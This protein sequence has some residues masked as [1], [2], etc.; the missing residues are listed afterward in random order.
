MNASTYKPKIRKSTFKKLFALFSLFAFVVIPL[1]G[2][3]A[4]YGAPI[5]INNPEPA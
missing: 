3:A 1:V 2:L 5:T 4:V